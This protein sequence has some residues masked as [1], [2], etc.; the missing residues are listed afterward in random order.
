MAV[1]LEAAYEIHPQAALRPEPFGALVYHYGTRRLVFL[2]KPEMV[3][4]VR[5]LS[6]HDTVADTLTSC[7]IAAKRWPTFLTALAGLAE[8]EIIRER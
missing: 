3:S 5:E 6:E 7:G 1:A 8:S 4:V 2:R